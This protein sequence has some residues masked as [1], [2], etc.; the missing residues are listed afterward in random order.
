MKQSIQI[1]D[2]TIGSGEPV[3]IIAEIGSN[4]DQDR[5]QVELL[6][7]KAV[8]AGADAV[9]FQLY[10]ADDLY[11]PGTPVFEILKKTELPE[12]WLSMLMEISLSMGVMFFASP[13]SRRAVDLLADIDVPAYKWASS[14]TVNLQLLK[15][16]AG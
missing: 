16:A 3:F 2:R 14:E 12:E 11:P 15:Y 10:R 7:E 8:E 5:D 13:F 4:H 6:I 1:G 9:K